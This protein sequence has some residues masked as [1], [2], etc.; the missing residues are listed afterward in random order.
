M[1]FPIPPGTRDVLPEEMRELRAI[2]DRMRTAFDEAGY[3][4][5]QTP[6][7]E[8]EDVLRRGEER[9]A[10]A[11]YR[12]FDEQGAVLA[13][14]SDMTIPIARV[15]A[16]RY[17]DAEPPLRFSYFARAWRA[18]ERGVGEPREFL[19]GGLELIGPTAPEGEAE[20]LALTIAALEEA[21]LRPPPVR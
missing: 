21:G 12:T 2:A 6:A 9:A 20:V 11:R 13:L 19:Q 14:R 10:G 8:Y 1:I 16:T 15:V 3:G 7:L 5:I 17:A 18:S 4:E